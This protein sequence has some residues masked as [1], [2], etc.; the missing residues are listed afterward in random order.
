MVRE[1]HESTWE[2]VK[3]GKFISQFKPKSKERP[4]QKY[5][6]KRCL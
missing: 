1:G 5:V 6:D 4:K 3:N 2:P